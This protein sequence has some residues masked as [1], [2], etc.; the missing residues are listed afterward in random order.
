MI[1]L[2]SSIFPVACVFLQQDVPVSS[3]AVLQPADVNLKPLNDSDRWYRELLQLQQRDPHPKPSSLASQQSGIWMHDTDGLLLP[4]PAS[5]VQRG[6]L[7]SSPEERN[8]I[9]ENHVAT[10]QPAINRLS[11]EVELLTTQNQA[12]NQRNQEMV[13]QLT[14]ADREIERLKV[15]LGNRYTEPNHLPEVEQQEKIKLE[16]LERQLSLRNRELLEAQMLIG[17]LEESLREM[18]ASLQLKS[19][20][21]AS[22][23]DERKESAERAGLLQRLDASEAELT[24]LQ[25]RLSQSELTCRQLKQQNLELKETAECY[26]QKAAE[27]EADIRRLTEEKQ[28]EADGNR[29]APAEEKIRQVIEGAAT[30]LQALRRLLELIDG[31]DFTKEEEDSAAVGSQLRWEEA[32][33]KSLLDK[34]KSDSSQTEEPLGELLHEAMDGLMLEKQVVLVGHEMLLHPEE[35]RRCGTEETREKREMGNGTEEE[36]N[37]RF[38]DPLEDLKA[39]TQTKISSLKLL[40]SSSISSSVLDRLLPAAERLNAPYSSQHA[41]SISFIH[42]AATEAFCCCLSSRLWSKYERRI[43]CSCVRLR[44]ENKAL[45]TRLSM[46][47]ERSASGGAQT[48]TSCQTEEGCQQFKDTELQRSGGADAEETPGNETPLMVVGNISDKSSGGSQEDDSDTGTQQISDL[49]AKVDELEEQLKLQEDYEQKMRI[50]QEQHETEIAK[51]KVGDEAD[52]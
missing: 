37:C 51:L 22:A 19:A 2:T 52:L 32:F 47:E 9:P 4:A 10:D 36:E 13:N 39:L 43:C 44:E 23:E 30:R 33:W 49:R 27:A 20:A 21:D 42:S 8:D 26:L 31:L 6:A 35:M 46:L 45:I 11:Q 41:A 5:D 12:L 50:L 15:E 18:E 3:E 29:S 34:M 40:A 14:E 28:E 38:T 48:S 24:E 16:D 25:S 17:S 1:F 7:W